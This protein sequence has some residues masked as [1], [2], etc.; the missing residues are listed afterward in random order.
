MPATLRDVAVAAGVH[1]ATAS[2]ALNPATTHRVNAATARKIR[3]AAQKLGY[4][5]NPIARGLKTNRSATLGVVIPDLTNP[6]F[7]P[8]V[9]GIDD[10]ASA[11]GYSTLI[12][13][14]DGDPQREADTISA[15]RSRQAEG[16]IVATAVLDHPLLRSLAADAVPLVLVNRVV[17]S[18]T[19]SAVIGDDTA[20][21]RAAVNHLVALGH[22]R[23]AHIA[24][25]LTT[26][27]GAVR[28]RA[29]REA[30]A[31]GGVPVV[32]ELVVVAER[33]REEAG[34]AAMTTLLA[35]GPPTAVFAANDLLALGC[36]D[37]LRAVG[38]SCPGDV[39]VVGFNDMPF[40]D[41]MAP[42][43]TTVR[44]PNYQIGRE[45]AQLLLD[46]VRAPEP[47]AAK[48]VLLP[49]QL[50]VR[51]STAPPPTAR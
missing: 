9:R 18:L 17:E 44:V 41:K 35:D 4:T 36:Y 7:P 29:F 10:V 31:A 22:T 8:I 27:T 40:L 5:P 45:A 51:E 30:M 42:P 50:V 20:G 38:L 26:S 28:L 34:A 14:T 6:L 1:P 15:L 49:L 39:S 24:G 2:R 16:L 19:A 37:A 21:V 46:M 33:Y 12:V 48:A 47:P 43:L 11:A 32:D 25:P 13:N 23:I 3:R